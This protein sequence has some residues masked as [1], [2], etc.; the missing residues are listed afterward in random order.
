MIAWIRYHIR[1]HFGFSKTETNGVLLLI[2]LIMVFLLAPQALQWYY[3]GK[4][5][6]KEVDIA[7]LDSM[8]M[9]LE[10]QVLDLKK[11]Q[12]VVD[13]QLNQRKRPDTSIK[14]FD[15]N[16]ADASHLQRIQGIGPV[17]S[18][19]IVKYRDKLGGY[20]DKSQYQEIYGLEKKVFERLCEYSYI[21][22][23]FLPKKINV[24][25]A[26]FKT[27]VSHPY[28]KYEQVKKIMQ[29]RAKH[30]QLNRLEDLVSLKILDEANFSKVKFYL[31]L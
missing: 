22:A 15:I 27:L 5:V 8:V 29:H 26:D 30:G 18:A 6:D 28:L 17:L 4:A 7:L 24:N 20:I 10:K 19:R 16:Q 9:D 25:T 12:P 31:E 21:T 13:N 1:N 23:D 14:H 3:A 2:L 11:K